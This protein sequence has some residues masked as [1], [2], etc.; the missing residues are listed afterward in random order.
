MDERK[1]NLQD[2]LCLCHRAKHTEKEKSLVRKFCHAFEMSA[3][4]LA[5]RL[6]F[7]PRHVRRQDVARLLAKYE[8][9]KQ[10]LSVNGSI[11]ECGVL[12]GGGNDDLVTLFGYS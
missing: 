9:F 12:C 11:I 1:T 7:F 6:Q 8:V 3:L 5:Q 2:E 10:S 4:P